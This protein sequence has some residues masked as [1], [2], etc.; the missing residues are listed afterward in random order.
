[1]RRFLLLLMTTSLAACST[2]SFEEA[3]SLARE[4]LPNVPENW[5]S[6]AATEDTEIQIGWIDQ[7]SDESLTDLVKRAQ[8]R[9]QDLR[10]AAAGV[11]RAKG[12]LVQ[13][14]AERFPQ[15]TAAANVDTSGNPDLGGTNTRS[16]FLGLAAAWELDVWGRIRA[17]R[18]AGIG[19][20][21]SAEEDFKFAQ[22][23]IA[24]SVARAYFAAIEA[25]LQADVTSETLAALKETDR[26]VRTR[27]EI[28]EATREDISLS[29]SEVEATAATLSINLADARIARRA[30]EVLLKDYPGAQIPITNAFPV[31]PP[32]PTVGLPSTLLD[33]RP[34]IIAASRNVAAAS[35]FLVQARAARLPNIT[36]SGSVGASSAAGPMGALANSLS[37]QDILWSAAGEILGVVFA[38][39]TR[40]AQVKIERADLEIAL[41]DYVN[42]AL[43]AFE[44]VENG[45]DQVAAFDDQ[46]KRLKAATKASEKA[47]SLAQFRYEEGETDLVDV[48]DIRQRVLANQSGFVSA[49]RARL[50]AWVALNLALGGSWKQSE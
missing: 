4:N 37:P 48:L 23:S 5:T 2:T 12:L 50:D 21:I 33:R 10:T 40:R 18:R 25:K 22:Y 43:Q 46:V 39:G 32:P 3:D 17:G 45:L 9:N 28:G 36:L 34:D 35:N 1:M 47:F 41:A 8:E 31:A 30:L 19:S 27:F 20:F 6:V 15:V 13:L 11:E 14:G 49:Q 38:G 7:L 24:A 42:I 26:I 16:S 44:E 29:R